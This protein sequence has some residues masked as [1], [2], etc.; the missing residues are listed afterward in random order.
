[1]SPKSINKALDMLGADFDLS[2]KDWRQNISEYLSKKNQNEQERGELEVRKEE[3]NQLMVAGEAVAE[4]LE[5]VELSLSNLVHDAQELEEIR[6]SS[7]NVV[8]DNIDLKVLASDMT[9]DDQNKD[10]HWCNHNAYLDRVNPQHISDEA[11]IADLEGVPNS[12]F[13]PGLDDQDSLLTDFTVLVRRVLVEHL[14]AFE[15]FK[16]VV[17]LHIKHK[18]SD[19]LKKKTETVCLLYLNATCV[20]AVVIS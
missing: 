4:Q 16:D 11:P 2:L 8:L 9:S 3:L 1:M 20:T 15:V 6:P 17:P 5:A 7:F 18:Y 19:E 14:P 12:T 13:L 10:Y